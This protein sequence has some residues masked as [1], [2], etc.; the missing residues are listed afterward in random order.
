MDVMAM[1]LVAQSPEERM[2]I[3]E[4]FGRSL[5]GQQIVSAY[6]QKNV[7]RSTLPQATLFP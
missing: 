5:P 3:L 4:I 6:H 1:L 7:I 2:M